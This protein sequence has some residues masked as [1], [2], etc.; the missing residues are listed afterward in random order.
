MQ[1]KEKYDMKKIDISS[2]L[3]DYSVEFVAGFESKL[4]EFEAVPSTFVIDQNVY[5]LY[6]DR[7]TGIDKA[8]IFMIDAIESKKNMD[9]VMDLIRFWKSRGVKKN[10]K[11][12]CFGG[13]IAQDITTFASNI[14]LRNIDWYFFPT[15]L[16]SM[17]DSC[18]GGKCGI[19]FESFKNQL[20][21]FYPPKKI[22]ID[23]SFLTTL[24]DADYINGWGEILKFSL[25]LDESFYLDLKN[26]EKYIP[27]DEI[28]DYIYRGLEVKKYVIEKDEFESDL[29]RVLNYGH[30]FGHALESYT[31]NIIP[32]GKAVI[33]GI[34]VV[35]YIAYKEGLISKDI[36]IDVKA[37]IKEAFITEEI[38]VKEPQKLFDI[39]K[40]D[41]KVHDNTIYL[42]VLDKLSHLIV[43]PKTI[44]AALGKTF[45]DYLSETHSFYEDK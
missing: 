22:F 24:P 35:N 25:T 34:D 7:F 11:V 3:Y 19:N 20:G 12:I 39:I 31:N 33:W 29:R 1:I 43:Y 21:V 40:F 18:I 38:V 42:A 26:I 4:K 17:C 9:T 16:L 6:K 15:T 23:S 45:E 27:C 28:D 32:H 13:G 10:Y 30:T 41:K 8:N 36:Y 2:S 14:Y 44:D 37:L 5:D